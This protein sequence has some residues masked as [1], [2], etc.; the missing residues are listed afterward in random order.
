MTFD[1]KLHWN[2]NWFHF[3]I[4]GQVIGWRGLVGDLVGDQMW[5]DRVKGNRLEGRL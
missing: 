3:A 5:G 4:G 2:A 1:L